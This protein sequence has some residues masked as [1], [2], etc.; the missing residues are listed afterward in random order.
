MPY[1][2]SPDSMARATSR[3][4]DPE[5]SAAES[6]RASDTAGSTPTPAGQSHSW[7]RPI[8]EA[9]R[10]SAHTISVADGS[11]ETIRMRPP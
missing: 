11:S 5:S 6:I 3:S 8:S 1:S 9:R 4:I 7:L 10:P 2:C